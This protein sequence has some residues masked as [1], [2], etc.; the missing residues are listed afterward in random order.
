MNH[1]A[2]AERVAA[3]HLIRAAA[4]EAC[5]GVF[6]RRSAAS[7]LTFRVMVAAA[8]GALLAGGRPRVAG[9][10]AVARR[11]KEVAVAV[12]KWPQ[13]WEKAREFLGVASLAE[14]PA[15]VRELARDGYK[16]L[17]KAL[18]AAFERWPLKLYTLPEARALSVNKALDQFMVRFPRFKAWLTESVKPRVDQFDVWLREHLPTLSRV[19]M[20]A[21]YVWVWFN[22]VEFEWD[23]KGLI[24]AAT[25]HLTLSDLL[26]SIPGSVL[27]ALLN[28][29]GLGTFTL[30][31]AAVVARFAYLAA[32]RYLAW[33]DGGVTVDW[34][35]LEE[36]FG[37][38]AAA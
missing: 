19:V 38:P 22:V 36:D 12:R 37:S 25:G 7:D 5:R 15:R 29:F 8:D 11:M 1:A 23:L 16:A 13:L 10:A 9:L 18:S 14:L 33:S 28:G 21:V 3:R 27:G 6:A 4:R 32:R 17:S 30:L 26:G 34:K 35:R 24:E 2:L 20:V 31:P